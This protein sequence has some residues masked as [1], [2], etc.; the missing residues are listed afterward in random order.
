MPHVLLTPHSQIPYDYA[1]I[2]RAVRTALIRGGMERT[3][4]RD[5]V[6]LT[7]REDVLT[8]I[9]DLAA[10]SGS[11]TRNQVMELLGMT[12]DQARNRLGHLAGEGRLVKVGAKYYPAGAVVPPERQYAVI[13]GHLEHVGQ[14]YRQ[15]LADLLRVEKKQCGWIL[16]K[17]VAE[18]KLERRGQMYALPE[19]GE[20]HP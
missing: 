12:K 10:E 7:Q 13:R 14:A 3:T 5:I 2:S 18:G 9:M 15:E 17:L 6:H 16:Q 20:E 4:L 11:V 19:E 1:R 8:R